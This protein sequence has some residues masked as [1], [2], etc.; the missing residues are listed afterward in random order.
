MKK[1]QQRIEMVLDA[2]KIP[3]TS[4]DIATEEGA[5][6]KMRE[7]TGDPKAFPPQLVRGDEYLGVSMLV[8]SIYKNQIT[9]NLILNKKTFCRSTV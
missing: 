9:K 2:K 3:F 1:E 8:I 6:E 7:I 5:K 4:I